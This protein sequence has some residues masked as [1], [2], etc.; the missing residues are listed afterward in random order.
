MRGLSLHE[1]LS[2]HMHGAVHAPDFASLPLPEIRNDP[3]RGKEKATAGNKRPLSLSS[4][5]SH[6]RP[7]TKDII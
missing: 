3:A 6:Q 4:P 5:S 2:A 7:L 1:R